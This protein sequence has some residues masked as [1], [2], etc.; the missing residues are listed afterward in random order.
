MIG[1]WFMANERTDFKIRTEEK[2]S[3][4]AARA[5]LT[6]LERSGLALIF[7][8]RARGAGAGLVYC[9]TAINA[10]SVTAPRKLTV[11]QPWRGA[12]RTRAALQITLS[13]SSQSN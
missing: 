3:F 5:F 13:Y 6:L 12:Q 8:R 9:A 7:Q 10:G 1:Y 11:G 4:G 2:N